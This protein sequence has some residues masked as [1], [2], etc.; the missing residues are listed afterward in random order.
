MRKERCWVWFRGG[1]NEASR[2]VGGFQATTDAEPGVLIQ[3]PGYR[4]ARV[5]SWRVT[6]SEPA[7]LNSPPA[8]LDES[9]P[10]Q[11]F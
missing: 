10:W 11:F 2:W 4:D 7:D 5:P 6:T 9:G 8:G 3:H 1:L